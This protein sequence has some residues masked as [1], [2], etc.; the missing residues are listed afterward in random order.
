MF[1]SFLTLTARKNFVFIPWLKGEIVYLMLNEKAMIVLLFLS[2]GLEN[3][4]LLW[5]CDFLG[6]WE[7]LYREK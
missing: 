2:L 1:K 5:Y 6:R 4:N 3:R 7:K